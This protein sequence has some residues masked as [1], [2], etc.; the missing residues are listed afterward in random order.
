MLLCEPPDWTLGGPVKLVDDDEDQWRTM[1]SV[2][3]RAE[4][5][6]L[7]LAPV[8]AEPW[9]WE[10]RYADGALIV[11]GHGDVIE[12]T[13]KGWPDDMPKGWSFRAD[14]VVYPFTFQRLSDE[15]GKRVWRAYAPSGGHP[16]RTPDYRETLGTQ[17]DNAL[18][19]IVYDKYVSFPEP[20]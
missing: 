11:H 19:T 7:T 15:D 20:D 6:G 1:R 2:V 8:G 12:A 14:G 10:L 4:S 16:L 18:V 3:A 9:G 17:P 13:L 5:F